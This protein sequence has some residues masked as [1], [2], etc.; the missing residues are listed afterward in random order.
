MDGPS[1]YGTVECDEE[2][3]DLTE[4]VTDSPRRSDRPAS[5]GPGLD[6][7]LHKG[8]VAKNRQTGADRPCFVACGVA[9]A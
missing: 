2:I 3:S 9:G 7:L 4:E 1:F 6:G 8:P 5:V